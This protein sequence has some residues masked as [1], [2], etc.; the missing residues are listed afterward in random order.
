[1]I[2]N[3]WICLFRAFPKRTK[4]AA[5]SLTKKLCPGR[6]CHCSYCSTSRVVTV[7]W[8]HTI[9]YILDFIMLF[10]LPKVA[11]EHAERVKCLKGEFTKDCN[12]NINP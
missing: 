9:V 12:L 4:I 6:N 10:F 5:I 8:M 2:K 3:L 1:M 11:V 7:G